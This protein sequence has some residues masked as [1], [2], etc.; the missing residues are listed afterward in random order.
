ME[1]YLSVPI[2]TQVDS[3]TTT[4]TTANKLVQSGQ[5]FDVTVQVGDVVRNTTDSTWATVTAVDSATILSLSADIMESGETFEIYS[6]TVSTNQLMSAKNVV[7]CS[8]ATTATVT[9]LYSTSSSASDVLTIT[10]KATGTGVITV[11]QAF[12]DALVLAANPKSN[13]SPTVQVVL[14]TGVVVVGMALA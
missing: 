2:A 9:V 8:Q 3:G 5:S 11:R 7:F 13:P 1:K 10:H 14:P 6:A 4:A 12:E